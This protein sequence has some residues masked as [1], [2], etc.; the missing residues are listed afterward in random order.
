[1]NTFPKNPPRKKRDILYH[2]NTTG[3]ITVHTAGVEVTP[4]VIHKKW[5]VKENKPMKKGL[6]QVTHL[7]T[8]KGI[9]VTGSYSFCKTVAEELFDEPL[10]YLPCETMWVDHPDVQRVGQKIMRLKE[11]HENLGRW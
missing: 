10:L 4:F 5:L 1:M 3:L 11:Q 8:G 9:G 7:F 2:T 6:W